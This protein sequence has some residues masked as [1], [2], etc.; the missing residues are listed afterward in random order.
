MEEPVES[1]E[2]GRRRGESLPSR[3]AA[4]TPLTDFAARRARR[5]ITSQRST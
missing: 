2:L 4:P 5:Y 3:G 1:G